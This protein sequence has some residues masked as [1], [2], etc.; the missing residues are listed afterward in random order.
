MCVKWDDVLAMLY[1]ASWG[2]V[3]WDL[4]CAMRSVCDGVGC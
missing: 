4:K 1:Q 2:R 3:Q